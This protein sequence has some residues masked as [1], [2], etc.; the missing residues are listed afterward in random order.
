MGLQRNVLLLNASNLKTAL[1]Y[2]Y[3]FV[4]VSEIADRFGIHT[5]LKDLYG[6]PEI[7]WEVYLQKQL[8]KLTF[9][10]IL[11]TLRNSDAV[12]VNDYNSHLTNDNY[13]QPLISQPVDSQPYYPI[14]ATKF[15]I[16]TLRKITEIPIVIGGFAF[17]FMPEKLMEYLRPDY[18]VIGAPDAFFEHFDNVIAGEKLDHIAN[19]IYYQSETLYRGPTKFFPPATRREYTEAIVADRQA[20][21]S[22]FSGQYFEP[23]IAI[24]VSRGCPHHCSMCSEPSVK[25]RIVQYR[26]LDIIV[27]EIN[28]LRKYQ[29]NNLF[30]IC[31]EINNA[32]NEFV[33]SLADRLLELNKEREDYE[34]ISWY[35]LHLMSFS[36]DELKH[37][38]NSG[39]LGTFNPLPI[40]SLDDYH[41]A[42]TE[43]PL[44][45]DDIVDFFTTAKQVM[46]EEFQQDERIFH[47]VEERVFRAPQSL[48]PGN[49]VNAW[50]IF[51]GHIET[52]PETIA[53]TIKRA[54]ETGLNEVF[55]SCYVNKATRIYDFMQPTEEVLNHTWSSVNGK[56]EKSYNELWPSFTYPPAL[57]R[58]FGSEKVV[59]KFFILIGDTFLSQKHLFKKDWNW[60][61][62]TYIDPGRFLAWWNVAIKSEVEFES[63]TTISEVQKF[64]TFL[65]DSPTPDN[66]KLLF[67]PT[68]SRKKLIN[69][70][71]FI[72]I[73]YV[74]I[75][76]EKE[77]LPII[78]LLG[79]PPFTT[80][81]NLSPYKIALKFFNQ[82]SN[83]DDLF[84][85]LNDNL[86]NNRL[87][88]LFVEF[89]LYFKNTPLSDEY[90]IFFR[91]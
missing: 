84:S 7:Q 6:I 68:P 85:L 25:G 2:P 62:T 40:S 4:Q 59:E 67:N 64:L 27:E 39:F 83:K 3:A 44:K 73:Q 70:A 79:L 24:E 49:F 60:F 47:S 77:L 65:R 16:Q 87:S 34:K 81:L 9:S 66:L 82:F 46:E 51:L 76:Q 57:I 20:F 1:T 36:T 63:L 74:L 50:N 78:E 21:F 55:D 53:S 10:L 37:L 8:Q 31:S 41:L 23:S 61:L 89:L 90:Q 38:R 33:L 35:A 42:K 80:I 14:E 43:V 75:S 71:T 18:G 48:N 91:L 12:D 56:I 54:D 32:G 28:F 45:S 13:H 11:I 19:L 52:T 26:D 86:F 58:H 17:S 30:F 29:L 22:Q 15:L 69:F 5:V 72:A 88:R